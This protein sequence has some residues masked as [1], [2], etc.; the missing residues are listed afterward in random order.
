VPL[1]GRALLAGGLVHRWHQAGPGG[2]M[3]GGREPGHVRAGLRDDDLSDLFP[4]RGNGLQ[5]LDLVL[6]GSAG[7]DNHRIQLGRRLLD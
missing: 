2:Q 4:D 1:T 6:P 3:G 5:Q 7:V